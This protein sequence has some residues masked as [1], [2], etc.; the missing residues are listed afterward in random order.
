MGTGLIGTTAILLYLAVAAAQTMS[1]FKGL[2][3]RNWIISGGLVAMCGHGYVVY[4]QSF[5]DQGINISIYSMA[6]L[7]SCTIAATVLLSALRKPLENLLIALLP[8]SA[9][10]VA[11]SLINPE[12]NLHL[13]QLETNIASHILLAILAYSILAVAALH[14]LVV[15][16]QHRRL[17]HPGAMSLLRALPPMQT[18]ESLLFELLWVGWIFLTLSI[19]SGFLFLED[20]FAQHVVHHTFLT[21]AAWVVFLILLAGR[22]WLGW[23]GKKAINWTL[24]GFVLLLIGYFGSKLVVEI[25]LNRG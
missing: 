22:V 11:V 10:M 12:S 1:L 15:Q 7:V 16:Y 18:M 13:D 14:S 24:A 4:L 9:V 20:M 17:K 8:M 21:L 25:I 23:R 19:L 3:F 5:T 2:N 6:S